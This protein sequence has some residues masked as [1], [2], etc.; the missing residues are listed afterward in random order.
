MSAN[1]KPQSKKDKKITRLYFPVEFTYKTEYKK[2]KNRVILDL[3]EKTGIV[4]IMSHGE[5]TLRLPITQL[6]LRKIVYSSNG[7][8]EITKKMNLCGEML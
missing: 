2:Y 7:P 8:S 5:K 1:S 3:K 6:I 4:E